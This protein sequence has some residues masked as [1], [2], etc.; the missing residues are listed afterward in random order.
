MPRPLSAVTAC[1][2]HHGAVAGQSRRAM[3]QNVRLQ[4]SGNMFS[5]PPLPFP[6]L[7]RQN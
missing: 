7:Y 4:I 2:F 5:T 3:Q 1:V 6:L